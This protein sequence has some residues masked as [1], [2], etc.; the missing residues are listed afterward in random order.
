MRKEEQRR[1]RLEF[2][3]DLD[4]FFKNSEEIIPTHN[5]KAP[6][7]THTVDT[8]EDELDLCGDPHCAKVNH[9]E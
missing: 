5:F 6:T 7:K 9:I 1:A 2:Q 4:R 8:F 3:A